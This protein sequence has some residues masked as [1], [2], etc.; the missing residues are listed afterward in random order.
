M[1]E[2][3]VERRLAAILVADIAG[4]SRL[5]AEDEAATVAA[6]KG[7]QAVVLPLVEAHGGR[8][9]DT[10]GDGILAE[11]RS[12]QQAVECAIAIQRTMAERNATV[13]PA[14]QMR[15]RIGVNL[16]DVMYDGTRAYGDGLNVAAR[17]QALADPGGICVTAM[18]REEVGARTSLAFEDLGAQHLKNI[19]RPVRVF[20]LRHDEQDKQGATTHGAPRAWVRPVLIGILAVALAGALGLGVRFALERGQPA[21]RPRL[22]I[23]VL[24]FSNMSGDPGQDYFSDGLTEDL[25][26]DLS[27]IEGAFVIARNTM[28]SYRGKIVDIKQ[29]GRELGV[30]YVLEGSVRRAEPQVRV[31]AQLIDAE[32]GAHIW[33]ERFDRGAEDL[34]SFQTEVTG[35][36][37]R[38]LNLQ[39]KE[40]ESQRATRGRPENIEAVDYARKAW[41]ELWNKPPA[42]E[43]NDQAFAYIEKALALDPQVPEIWTNLSYAHARAA[44]SRWSLS[45]SGS[46]QLARAAGE[47]AVELDPRSA[48]A[49]YVLGFAIRTQGDIDRALEENETAVIL[50]PNHA[51]GHAGIGICWLMR[52]RPR[53]ALP[54]FDRAFRLSPRDPLR[55][56][57]HTWVGLAYMMLGNDHKA[58]EESK[59]S[60]A[61]NPK[62]T[63][64]FTLQAAALGLL[65]REG[66]AHAALAVRQQLG[67]PGLTITTIK[68]GS[69]SDYPEYSRLMERYYEGLRQAGLPE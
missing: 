67:P 13:P 14:R 9:Q 68:E 65:G 55:S 64:A 38:T 22:S 1:D 26:T 21:D 31:N 17:V 12:V 44:V 11:F 4:Y 61:A 41:A 25:T 30:R 40:A 69:P 42:R 66:E 32:T 56:G 53:E 35:Q 58:L 60:V 51:P 18:V 37:A 23:A 48:D 24:P 20:H 59:R 49:H 46:L 52:G 10:A 15:F 8:I 3:H 50:N 29:L 5:M 27:R 57:W 45:R 28:Q 62:S 33:A 39:L 63:G 36:I 34:F 16:G 6:L 43:T 19:P 7:H 54:Y 2:T 47:R